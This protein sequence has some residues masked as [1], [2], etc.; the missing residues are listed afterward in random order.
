MPDADNATLLRINFFTP[1]VA[2]GKDAP[3]NMVKLVQKYAPY[4]SFIREM[5]F[6]SLD[7]QNL[8]QVSSH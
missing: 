7:G 8:T 5:T 3:A 1:G 4:A 6:R 2:L